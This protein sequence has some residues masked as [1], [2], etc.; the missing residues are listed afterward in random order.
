MSVLNIETY[1]YVV[2]KNECKNTNKKR[3][4]ITQALHTLNFITIMA[5]TDFTLLFPVFSI[6]LQHPSITTYTHF[7]KHHDAY[8]F[9]S[10]FFHFFEFF[11][12]KRL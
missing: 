10:T 7:Y 6:F 12:N 1:Q 3:K 5:L 8:R 9:C 11:W 2:T 4:L